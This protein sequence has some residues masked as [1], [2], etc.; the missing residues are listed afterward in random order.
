MIP[1]LPI[2][3]CRDLRYESLE[4]TQA[5][6]WAK[7]RAQTSQRPSKKKHWFE[8]KQGDLNS[9]GYRNHDY[10]GMGQNPGT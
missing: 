7:L 3:F 6:F 8:S 2:I 4:Y 1:P 9:R 5:L 10:M